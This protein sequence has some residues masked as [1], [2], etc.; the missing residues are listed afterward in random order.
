MSFLDRLLHAA[1]H[2]GVGT[3]QTEIADALGA[4]RQTVNKW[5]HGSTPDTPMIAHIAN[6]FRVDPTWLIS[7][8]GQPTG[9]VNPEGLSREER[10][11]VRFYRNSP[12]QRRKALYDMAKALAKAIVVLATTIPGFI[13]QKAEAGFNIIKILPTTHCRRLLYRSVW[14]FQLLKCRGLLIATV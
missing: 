12:P 14:L 11:I 6:A 5:F 4:R 10:D 2:A 3:T 9:M 13:P 8:M 1:N 7:G